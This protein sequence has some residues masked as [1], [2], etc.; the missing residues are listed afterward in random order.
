MTIEH[1]T[2]G[3]IGGE[4]LVIA[5]P[6]S[7]PLGLSRI[8]ESEEVGLFHVTLSELQCVP[9]GH[10]ELIVLV[11]C[12]AGE[13]ALTQAKRELSLAAGCYA[14]IPEGQAG[15]IAARDGNAEALLF[16]GF[17]QLPGAFFNSYGSA[18]V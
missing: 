3:D 4:P 10:D 8:F 6:P 13:I 1:V 2:V 9:V 5:H 15:E 12:L 17:E 16:F 18:N 14:V 7:P 11:L